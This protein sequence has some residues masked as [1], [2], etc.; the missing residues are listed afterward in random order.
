MATHPAPGSRRGTLVAALLHR[1]QLGG[2][3]PDP[4]R[5]GIVHRLDKDTTG[6]IVVAKTPA[7]MH[8][9]ARQFAN[10]RVEKRYEAIVIGAPARAD[11]LVDLPIGRD[12]IVRQ[13]MQARIGQK[14]P[15]R[16][17]YQVLE[18]LGPAPGL[19]PGSAK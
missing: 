13:R 3:W 7:A 4:A 2:D 19:G 17:R 15:A 5:P 8:A 11:G 16:T 1:F 18:V 10:R 14:R 12:P 6:V 9:L